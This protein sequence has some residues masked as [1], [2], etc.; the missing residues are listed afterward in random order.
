MFM[1]W[2]AWARHRHPPT[3]CT[4]WS[5]VPH[6]GS[7]KIDWLRGNSHGR[8]VLEFSVTE[9]LK[10]RILQPISSNKK[11]ITPNVHLLRS[12]RGFCNYSK[13]NM[14]SGI[15][16]SRSNRINSSPLGK[17][18]WW[19]GLFYGSG[20]PPGKKRWFRNK[21]E[22]W[23]QRARR[24]L[25]RGIISIARAN[26]HC[27]YSPI[28]DQFACLVLADVVQ[29]IINGAKAPGQGKVLLLRICGYWQPWRGVSNLA[30]WYLFREAKGLALERLGNLIS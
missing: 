29:P 7:M 30:V 28:G 9:I 13:S 21:F 23:S 27:K 6:Y 12:I 10:S 16:T 11:R 8:K 17:Y 3:W 5:E 14:M 4:T 1:L 18:G 22:R 20:F 24:F 26:N 15:S 19:P 2:L 25:R